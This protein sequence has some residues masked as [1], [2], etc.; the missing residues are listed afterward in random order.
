M[1]APDFEVEVRASQ[2]GPVVT[3]KGELDI[4]TAGRLREVLRAQERGGG[5]I[6]LDLSQLQFIDG[7]GLAVVFEAH[8]RARLDGFELRVEV[9]TG[10]A[11]RL[12]ELIGAPWELE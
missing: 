3:P 12:I 9:G 10:M 6:E 5:L 8:E 4:A 7:S 2:T 11:R 1:I